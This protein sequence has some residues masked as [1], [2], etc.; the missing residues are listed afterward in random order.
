MNLLKIIN[1]SLL[2]VILTSCSSRPSRPQLYP[3]A[4]LKE[5]GEMA[6]GD[7]DQCLKESEAY[8]K[9]SEGEKLAKSYS[10]SRVGTSVGFGYGGGGSGLG[11]GMDV[12]GGGESRLPGEEQIRRNFANQCLVNKGYQVVGWG[13]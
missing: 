11:L 2:C 13:D 10:G 5:R 9:T 7:V 6:P 3:N 8:L 4:T 12:G 1:Y